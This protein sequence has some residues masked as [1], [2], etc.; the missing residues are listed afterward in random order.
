[1]TTYATPDERAERTVV[2][3]EQLP[4]ATRLETTDLHEVS[5]Y[6]RHVE[7][8]RRQQLDALP[9]APLDPVVAAHRDSVERILEGVRVALRRVDEGRYGTCTDCGEA[10]AVERLRVRPWAATCTRCVRA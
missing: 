10:I 3:P 4:D 9:S 2:V 7:K 8:V 6:L 5:A 1:M